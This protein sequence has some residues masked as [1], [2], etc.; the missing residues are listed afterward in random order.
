ML[1]EIEGDEKT[2]FP[3][4]AFVLNRVLEYYDGPRLLLQESRAGQ[5]YLAWW[6]ASDESV[7]RWLYLPLSE[8]RLHDV[9]SG[10][11]PIL[12]ALHDP[13]DGSLVVVDVDVDTD[14]VL[15]AL[16][17][18]AEALPSDSLPVAGTR[19]NIPLP[20]QFRR[21][22]SQEGVHTLDLRLEGQPGQLAAELVGRFIGNLQRL[23]D[24]IGQVVSEGPKSRGRVKKD[25]LDHTRLNFV[26]TYTSSLGLRLETNRKEESSSKSLARLSLE[27]LF[28]LFEDNQQT[29]FSNRAQTV[30]STRVATNYGNFLST[31]E[32]LHE[33]ATIQWS[34]PW[35]SNIR[36]ITIT[37]GEA[38]D[39]RKKL[40]A[41]TQDRQ[42]R[43]VLDGRFTAGSTRSGR[44]QFEASGAD[45]LLRV[46]VPRAKYRQLGPITLGSHY[47]VALDPNLQINEATGEEKTTY[48]LIDISAL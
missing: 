28:E 40:S 41:I 23:L 30:L 2:D 17:T 31:I 48:T 46:Y 8:R 4:N 19:H 37:P 21:L 16:T 3:W 36:K 12:E 35:R 6:N 32:S 39:A 18:T 20:E 25:I 5:L 15:Q 38:A 13:E 7:D 42:E 22:P 43:L 44:F 26:G 33:P 47:Q 29:L 34:L 1:P 27:S 9:L 45:E 11:M 10:N 14:S 24:S